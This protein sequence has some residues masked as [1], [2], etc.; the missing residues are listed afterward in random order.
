[1]IVSVSCAFFF[2]RG[3]RNAAPR[4]SRFHAGSAPCNRFAKNAQ[5][6]PVPL[7]P[8]SAAVVA[9]ADSRPPDCPP[10]SKVRTIAGCN[11]NPQAANKKISREEKTRNPA[12]SHLRA[13][14]LS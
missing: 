12:S 9:A 4:C 11:R 5:Q 3:S 10:L 6:Q 13:D 2:T 7:A 14:S 1:M 8:C